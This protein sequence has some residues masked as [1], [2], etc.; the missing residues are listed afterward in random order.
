MANKH[1]FCKNGH[2]LEETAGVNSVGNRYCVPCAAETS[3]NHYLANREKILTRCSERRKIKAAE[4]RAYQKRYYR[5]NHARLRA[6][7]R[8]WHAEHKDRT[9][10]RTWELRKLYN[11]THA[12][13]ES[14]LDSQ[15]GT[16]AI[17]LNPEPVKGRCLAVDHCHKTGRVRGL[18]CGRCNTGIGN[19][20]ED[21]EL[22][23]TAIAYIIKGKL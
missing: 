21:P 5:E 15:G 11:L 7:N 12:Q 14:I 9:R 2:R 22:L 10:D 6:K 4:I 23:K 18:L 13:Y 16:C 19:F 17:C 3:R 20:R 1:T 8:K